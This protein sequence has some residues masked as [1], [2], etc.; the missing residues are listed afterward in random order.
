MMPA[1]PRPPPGAWDCH[2]HI[3]GPA[4][5]FPLAQRRAYD[6]GLANAA[7]AMAMLDRLGLT[8]TVL[9]Q[10]SVYG[11]DTACL[12]DA[13]HRF[14]GRAR[15][16]AVIDPATASADTLDA[17]HQA[18]VR[19]L[20]LN[21]VDG[22]QRLT[23][24]ELAMRLADLLP[25]AAGRGWH[26]LLHAPAG[27]LR[28]VSSRIAGAAVPIVLDHL[29]G[30]RADADRDMDFVVDLIADDGVWLKIS[31]PYRLADGPGPSARLGAFVRRLADRRPDRL[32]WGSDWP[33]T[34]AHRPGQRGI[35][36]RAMDTMHLLADLDRTLGDPV[37]AR[38]ILCDNPLVLYGP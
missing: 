7:A 35:G 15:G 23:P 12:V 16:V 29:A 36:F 3:F 37:L 25:V 11:T 4:D 34:S 26:L 18:G 27:H 10:P 20:R 5:R 30:V 9:V 6:P 28:A 13:L 19:G 24:A 32:L 1:D 38:R 22:D 33:H 8:R 2:I 21:W 31:A 14:D 17:L